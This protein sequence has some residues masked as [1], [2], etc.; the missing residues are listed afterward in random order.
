MNLTINLQTGDVLA[1]ITR[2]GNNDQA[3]S[4]EETP[5]LGFVILANTKIQKAEADIPNYKIKLIRVDQ[6]GNPVWTKLFPPIDVTTK[7]YVGSQLHESILS[8]FDVDIEIVFR[9][10]ESCP[11]AI[12]VAE[13]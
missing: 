10:H 12:E 13:V 7:D 1:V 6:N 3:Q 5:D 4:L 8:S 9:L 11:W 2:G